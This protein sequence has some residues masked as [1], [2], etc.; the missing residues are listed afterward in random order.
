MLHSTQHHTST[1]HMYMHETQIRPQHLEPCAQHLMTQHL[2][3]H[4][5]CIASDTH[6]ARAQ[7]TCCLPTLTA[8]QLTTACTRPHSHHRLDLGC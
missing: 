5:D 6:H 1:T 8:L 7:H 3:T 2:P 4:T